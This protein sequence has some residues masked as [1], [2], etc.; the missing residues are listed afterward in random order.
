VFH[1]TLLRPLRLSPPAPVVAWLHGP[2]RQAGS[3]GG[4]VLQPPPWL[5]N[6]R[7]PRLLKELQ[8]C[9]GFIV[10][11]GVASRGGY[12]RRHGD[13]RTSVVQGLVSVTCPGDGQ[14]RHAPQEAWALPVTSAVPISSCILTCRYSW[15]V[16]VHPFC[17]CGLML[18][19]AVR[20]WG[21]LFPLT[22]C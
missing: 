8:G 17:T 21:L 15:L 20:G 6:T 14:F 22:C 13:K 11:A 1:C 2:H 7:N 16:H 5:R 10:I 19:D 12:C 9:L 4:A 3:V 18:T